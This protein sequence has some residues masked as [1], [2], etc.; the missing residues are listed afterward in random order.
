MSALSGGKQPQ[1][2]PC[3]TQYCSRLSIWFI[4]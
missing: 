4:P 1:W 2:A 3:H